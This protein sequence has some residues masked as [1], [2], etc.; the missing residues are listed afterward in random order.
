VT[1]ILED[2]AVLNSVFVLA[3]ANMYH[4]TTDTPGTG[5]STLY[6][7][8][9]GATARHL[10][11]GQ[12]G[13][14]T[15]IAYTDAGSGFVGSPLQRVEGPISA[16]WDVGVTPQPTEIRALA[17]S[18]DELTCYAWDG[19]GRGWAIASDTGIAT[20]ITATLDAAETAQHA[21]HD[22]DDPIVYLATFGATAGT[23]YKYLPLADVL[24]AFYVPAAGQQAHRV[25]LGGA[26]QPS[27]GVLLLTWG[28]T[29]GGVYD[30][31]TGSWILKGTG[32]PSGWYWNEISVSA[33]NPSDWLILGSNGTFT[34]SGTSVVSDGQPV[35]W[36]SRDAGATWSGVGVSVPS[37][38]G[39]VRSIGWIGHTS[40]NELFVGVNTDA[41]GLHTRN[42]HLCRGSGTT[43]PTAVTVVDGGVSRDRTFR[44][45]AAG[46]DNEIV[47]TLTLGSAG[48]GVVSFFHPAGASDVTSSDPR[49][50]GSV[51]PLDTTSRAIV[52]LGEA[53][54][55]QASAGVPDYRA[56]ATNSP[57]TLSG[58]TEGGACAGGALYVPYNTAIQRIDAPTTAPSTPTTVYTAASGVHAVVSD[59]QTRTLLAALR[60]ADAAALSVLTSADGVTWTEMPA[61]TVAINS[62][63]FAVIGS[64][65]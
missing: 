55:F 25:G 35:L 34:I 50:G 8:P 61:P 63:G 45:L 12:S 23:T 29:G 11:R 4:A 62:T 22:P 16:T 48:G 28:V 38:A 57:I 64:A 33:T 40:T 27:A 56:G 6:A 37:G 49:I 44:G 2:P 26:P 42:A 14:T 53:S 10:V 60:G 18:T 36:R 43:L 1:A 58:R 59:A 9:S 5:W 46:R 47:G 19:D 52:V 15:W 3:G 65:S 7:G 41:G 24:A 21:L 13:A 17:L 31:T 32:L 51:R 30:G 54:G 39:A 20:A